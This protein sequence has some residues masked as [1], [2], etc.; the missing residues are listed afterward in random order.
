MEKI[1]E[2]YYRFTEAYVPSEGVKIDL[3][4]E[5]ID[6]EALDTNVKISGDFCIA[7]YL[8][9]SF[10]DELAAVIDKYRI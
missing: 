4:I 8:R 7:G 3:T 10:I 6:G 9:H 1:A 2:N 5:K